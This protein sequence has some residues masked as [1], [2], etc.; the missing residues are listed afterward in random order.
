MNETPYSFKQSAL[1]CSLNR[2]LPVIK[3]TPKY[4]FK[5]KNY[6]FA[7]TKFCMAAKIFCFLFLV[8]ASFFCFAEKRDSLCYTQNKTSVIKQQIVPVSLIATG[9]LLNIGDIKNKIQDGIPDF[10][11]KAD[12]YFPYVPVVQMYLADALGVKHQ[13]TVLNQTAYWFA[14]QFISDQLVVFLKKETNVTR[15]DG[16]SRSFPSG[17]SSVAFVSATVLFR[18]FKDTEPLLAWSGYLFA[19]ATSVFRMTKDAHWLPDV[20]A[21]AGIGILTT[22]IV[23]LIN[24]LKSFHPFKKN[25]DLAFTPIL[26]PRFA[27]IYVRF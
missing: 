3:I 20:L 24:P 9:A 17:H 25:K 12:E 18:E 4:F 6:Y 19:S 5:N 1:N 7:K 16:G 14:S 11:T 23:Y 15:P 8:L 22:N 27:G 21:G 10:N 13:S 26:S 2:R